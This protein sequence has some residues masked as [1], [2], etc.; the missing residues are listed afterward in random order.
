MKT[1]RAAEAINAC[2]VRVIAIDAQLIAVGKVRT[3]TISM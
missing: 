2:V 3:A 1:W